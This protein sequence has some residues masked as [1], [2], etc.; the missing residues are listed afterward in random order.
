MRRAG[1]NIRP[2]LVGILR[3]RV[4]SAQCADLRC[5]TQ[6][7]TQIE[8]PAVMR[9]ATGQ[10]CDRAPYAARP[11]KIALAIWTFVQVAPHAFTDG[12]RQ[13]MAALLVRYAE[14]AT[15]KTPLMSMCENSAT[16]RAKLGK[17]MRQ[18]VA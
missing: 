10:A 9:A 7:E 8:F 5:K 11:R 12:K 15:G 16:T 13:I 2:V 14:I 6:S 17:N 18:F 1:E 3:W 4:Q